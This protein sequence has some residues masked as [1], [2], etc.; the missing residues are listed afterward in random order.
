MYGFCPFGQEDGSFPLSLPTSGFAYGI[1]LFTH[2]T[3][4]K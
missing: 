4:S 2:T 1:P 3:S